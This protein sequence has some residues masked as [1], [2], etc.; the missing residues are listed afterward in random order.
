MRIGCDAA[1]PE[2]GE[3]A[4][5]RGGDGGD[6][7]EEAFWVAGVFVE[8]SGVDGALGEGVDG[9][10]EP[11]GQVAV[12]VKDGKVVGGDAEARERGRSA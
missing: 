6:G 11:G 5:E 1:E 10:V 9:A 8:G 4:D 12:G 2:A 7:A 3:G